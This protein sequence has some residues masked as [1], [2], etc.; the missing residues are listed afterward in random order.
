MK[1]KTKWTLKVRED[2]I[3]NI[4]SFFPHSEKASPRSPSPAQNSPTHVVHVEHLTRPF[5]ILQLKDLL[6]EDGKMVEAGFWTNRIK[7][8]CI[9]VV[10]SFISLCSIHQRSFCLVWIG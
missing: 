7:S 10:S 4:V 9:A 3:D 5:T 6:E 8:H 1:R 2:Y